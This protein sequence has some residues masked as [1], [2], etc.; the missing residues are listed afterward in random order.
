MSLSLIKKTRIWEIICIFSPSKDLHFQKK[1]LTCQKL[2][3]LL[4]DVANKVNSVN[5]SEK[6]AQR[7]L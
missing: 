2:M 6:N 7:N 5:L 3:A 4:T 1:N